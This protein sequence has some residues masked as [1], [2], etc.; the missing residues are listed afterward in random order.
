M[1]EVFQ[2]ATG[3]EA[4]DLRHSKSLDGIFPKKETIEDIRARMLHSVKWLDKAVALMKTKQPQEVTLSY[5]MNE[6]H[7]VG[8]PAG[9]CGIDP[10]F[11][12]ETFVLKVPASSYQSKPEEMPTYMVRGHEHIT[13]AALCEM[14]EMYTVTNGSVPYYHVF[15]GRGESMYDDLIGDENDR[16]MFIQRAGLFK[17][18]R[19][20]EFEERFGEAL[21]TKE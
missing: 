15:G 1:T 21:L 17:Q 20:F 18:D 5:W 4:L 3:E 6:D 11:Q 9:W 13:A 16:D 2:Q 8:C 14:F 7:T 12:A 19:M 10:E